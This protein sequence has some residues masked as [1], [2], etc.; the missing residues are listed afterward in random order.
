MGA[1][2]PWH[3]RR[4]TYLP[5]QIALSVV[6]AE[7]IIILSFVTSCRDGSTVTSLQTSRLISFK[8]TPTRKW[9]S[10]TCIWTETLRE[11]KW[12]CKVLSQKRYSKINDNSDICDLRLESVSYVHCSGHLCIELVCRGSCSSDAHYWWSRKASLHLNHPRVEL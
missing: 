3:R 8:N 5:P 11:F 9:S 4:F 2:I 10:L 12:G 6:I 7:R 1:W